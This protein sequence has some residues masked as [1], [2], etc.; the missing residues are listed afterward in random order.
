MNK[1]KAR[2][3]G[4]YI[5]KKSFKES[6]AHGGDKS[7]IGLVYRLVNKTSFEWWED[8]PRYVMCTRA[9]D[10]KGVLYPAIVIPA[11]RFATYFTAALKR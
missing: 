2:L 5:C 9:R 1:T 7:T 10:K 3:G 6:R 4:V 11:D 8:L